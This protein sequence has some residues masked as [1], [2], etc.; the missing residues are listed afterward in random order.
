V[1]LVA[2]S[3]TAFGD[4]DCSFPPYTYGGTIASIL[5]I[6]D[7]VVEIPKNPLVVIGGAMLVVDFP[8]TVVIT[9]MSWQ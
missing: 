4:E 9:R 3:K 6:A 5:L 8:F 7:T 2:Q 1:S